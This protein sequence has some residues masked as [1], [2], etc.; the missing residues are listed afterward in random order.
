MC[1]SKSNFRSFHSKFLEYLL[2][3]RKCDVFPMCV[4]C[5]DHDTFDCDF[6]EKA[7]G[8]SK[9]LLIDNFCVFGPLKCLMLLKN[10]EKSTAAS[11]ILKL[12]SFLT[13][14]RNS[15]I[16]EE[17][18]KNVVEP[19]MNSGLATL[20]NFDGDLIQKICGIIDGN[21]FEIRNVNGD[22]MKGIY[23][24]ANNLTHDCTPNTMM[25]VGFDMKMKILSTVPIE[26]G[27]LV[28]NGYVSPLVGTGVRQHLLKNGK[29]I[30]CTCERCQDPTE[31]GTFMSSLICRV[32]FESYLVNKNSAWI[33]QN[34]SCEM[35]ISEVNEILIDA[36]ND[37]LNADG[38]IRQMEYLLQKFSKIFHPN[39]YLIIDLKQSVA[40][41]LKSI[42]STSLVPP[43]KAVMERKIQLC[44]DILPILKVIQPG[45]SRL[46]AIAM[47]EYFVPLVEV[48]EID[49]EDKIIGKD[50]YLVS[51]NF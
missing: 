50:K 45:I 42:C 35:P 47:Y 46:N 24:F 43:G 22:S 37:I 41:I 6:F 12:P 25:A 9:N 44:E 27:S 40:S 49:Y 34:C 4:A 16:W 26:K 18:E 38:D 28:Q 32:C 11:E 2:F 5:E 1:A 13:E 29:Y 31:F 10:P 33:C 48:A 15:D 8:F 51:M 20:L 23:P 39:H 21:S 7:V 3:F 30:T 17:H 19:L 36:N 14:R